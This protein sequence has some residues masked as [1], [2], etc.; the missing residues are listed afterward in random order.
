LKLAKNVIAYTMLTDGIPISKI[1]PPLKSNSMLIGTVV[2][3]GQEQHYGGGATPMNREAL[4]LSGYESN[5]TLYTFVTA[6]NAFRK[7]FSNNPSYLTSPAIPIY[8]STNTLAFRK[9]NDTSAVITIINND[10]LGGSSRNITLGSESTGFGAGEAVTEV[11]SCKNVTVDSSGNLDVNI[12]SGL[13]MVF[14]KAE[15]LKGT[16]ICINGKTTGAVATHV[17][18]QT[19][20]SATATQ[21]GGKA[22]GGP[23]SSTGSPSKGNSAQ[24]LIL[25][26]GMRLM[27][28]CVAVMMAL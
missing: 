12:K 2:Y 4:W 7:A 3:Q 25:D 13:P 28:C 21:T 14:Y 6:L 24:R 5:S 17:S 19:T 16:T 23:G 22:T 10:G 8:N 15:L 20:A 1:L 18:T 27:V 11:V 9:G 26:M